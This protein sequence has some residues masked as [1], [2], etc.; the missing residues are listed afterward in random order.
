MATRV[1]KDTPVVVAL[2]TT[3]TRLNTGDGVRFVE[4]ST[5]VDVYLVYDNALDDGGAVGSAYHLIPAGSV[6]PIPVTGT[7]PLIA[8]A[9]AA[10]V[11][12]VGRPADASRSGRSSTGLGVVVG[13]RQ[14]S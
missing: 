2:G 10:D 8:G 6:Y 12:L 13:L 7:R 3:L 1:L 11:T 14:F 4:L 9:E 5:P